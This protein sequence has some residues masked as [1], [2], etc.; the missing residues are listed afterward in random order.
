MS[1]QSPHRAIE[2]ILDEDDVYAHF[3]R[4]ND[5]LVVAYAG[6]LQGS[7]IMKLILM[8]KDMGFYFLT[9]NWYDADWQREVAVFERTATVASLIQSA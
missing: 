8:A 3:D 5:S 1:D 4:E 9:A 7:E 6:D 2:I